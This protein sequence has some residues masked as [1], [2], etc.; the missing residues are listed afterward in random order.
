MILV[1]PYLRSGV[2]ILMATLAQHVHQQI[3][4]L[5]AQAIVIQRVQGHLLPLQTVQ[6]QLT[7]TET[8]TLTAGILVA[9]ATTTRPEVMKAAE[10]VQVTKT[11]AVVAEAAP[12]PVRHHQEAVIPQEVVEA[13]VAVVPVHQVRQVQLEAE[14]DKNIGL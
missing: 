1:A 11:A 12:I 2:Q 9:V 3:G 10:A 6:I 13:V 5:P 14:E 4:T 7:K 8:V